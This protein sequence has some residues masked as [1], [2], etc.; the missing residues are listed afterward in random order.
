MG[1]LELARSYLIPT[2]PFFAKIWP[3]QLENHCLWFTNH[4]SHN[5][6]HRFWSTLVF[7]R[8]SHKIN[9]YKYL[10][11]TTQLWTDPSRVVNKQSYFVTMRRR[12]AEARPSNVVSLHR[13]VPVVTGSHDI[14][15]PQLT[16]KTFNFRT[17][18]S[19]AS[20][21][22][23]LTPKNTIVRKVWFGQS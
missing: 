5:S 6:Y 17:Q 15:W 3:S 7:A 9:I 20:L 21:K 4:W 1:W 2:T 11:F 13:L 10:D 16:G 18:R 8:Q 14:T 22:P 12:I 19:L 23:Y